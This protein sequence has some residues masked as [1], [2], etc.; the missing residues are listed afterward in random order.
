M[1][2]QNSVQHKQHIFTF[3]G[4]QLHG[5]HGAVSFEW[6]GPMHALLSYGSSHAAFQHMTAGGFGHMH[7]TCSISSSFGNSDI[8]GHVSGE[9]SFSLK[10]EVILELLAVI[11]ELGAVIKES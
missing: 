7:I 2:Q 11:K 4:W 1:H 10:I 8:M 9:L 6:A 3:F 5:I